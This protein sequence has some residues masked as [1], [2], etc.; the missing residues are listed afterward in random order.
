MSTLDN[1]D[2][3]IGSVLTPFDRISALAHGR[4]DG[5]TLIAVAPDSVVATPATVRV[6]GGGAGVAYAHTFVEVG[7]FAEATLVLE[8]VGSTTLADNVEVA[9]ADGAKLTLVTV[10]DWASDAVQAQHLKVPARPRRAGSCTC[11]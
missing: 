6:V 9:V 1:D 5:A 4:A 3:R 8:Q 10:A 2:P 11:R 7:R